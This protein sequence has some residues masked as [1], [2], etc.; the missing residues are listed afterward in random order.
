V[1]K[2]EI[3]ARESEK[4][5]LSE[6]ERG[7]RL[8]DKAEKFIGAA[9]LVIG[10]KIFDLHDLEGASKALGGAGMSVRLEFLG[11]MLLGGALVLASLSRRIQDHASYPRGQALIDDLKSD[12]VSDDEAAIKVAKM[13]LD[14]H[15][16]NAGVNDQRARLLAFSGNLLVSGFLLAFPG[17]LITI[18]F[19]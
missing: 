8:T 17:R 10:L 13:Y 3:I 7:K 9:A 1:Q 4:A 11:F 19:R 18:F 2:I 15:D 14:L 6:I 16:Q 12:Q 5:F